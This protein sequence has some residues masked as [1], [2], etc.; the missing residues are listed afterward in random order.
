[1][2]GGN[3]PSSQFNVTSDSR[4]TVEIGVSYLWLGRPPHL[5]PLVLEGDQVQDSLER[6][7]FSQP[8]DEWFA[9]DAQDGATIDRARV[10]L[11]TSWVELGRPFLLCTSTY[12]EALCEH[13]CDTGSAEL[14]LRV[15]ELVGYP[16]ADK[17]MQAGLGPRR[18][19]ALTAA[20]RWR[21]LP[22][23]PHPLE[24]GLGVWADI[25]SPVPAA[26]P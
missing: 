7:P 24:L 3:R 2:A 12:P 6:A 19:T 20:E 17:A 18:P 1:M 26:W 22:D 16:L 9:F 13:V 23:D 10:E 21:Y 4:F 25:S 15:L 5:T 14:A 11:N 8:I